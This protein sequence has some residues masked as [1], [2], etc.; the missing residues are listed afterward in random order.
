MELKVLLGGLSLLLMDLSLAMDQGIRKEIIEEHIKNL[1]EQITKLEAERLLLQKELLNKEAEK[2][3]LREIHGDDYISIINK[4]Y[5]LFSPF[6]MRVP[7]E[8]WRQYNCEIFLDWSNEREAGIT[9]APEFFPYLGDHKLDG[10]SWK[11]VVWLESDEAKIQKDKWR[12][13]VI[14]NIEDRILELSFCRSN[15]IGEKDNIVRKE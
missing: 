3:D 13:Q 1:N 6:P 9:I 5:T 7:F 12:K 11:A 14:A 15:L 4:S 10:A 2:I 8:K